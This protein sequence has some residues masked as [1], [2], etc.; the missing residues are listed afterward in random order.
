[1]GS[2]DYTNGTSV[3]G[4]HQYMNRLLVKNSQKNVFVDVDDI[5]WIE[6]A[7]NYVKLHLPDQTHMIR[8]AL[9]NLESKLN[10]HQFVRIHRSKIVNIERVEE[11]EPWFSGDSK[12][13]LKNGKKLRMSRNYKDNLERFTLS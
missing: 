12:V 3:Q 2:E 4:Q 7:G 10:P 6:S 5:R 8:G 11:I 13:T 1:M 9:K